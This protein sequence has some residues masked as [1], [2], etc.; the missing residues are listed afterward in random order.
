MRGNGE[1]VTLDDQHRKVAG[2]TVITQVLGGLVSI[3]IVIGFFLTLHSGEESDMQAMQNLLQTQI[4]SEGV[5]LTHLEDTQ[6]QLSNSVNRLSDAQDRQ[7]DALNQLTNALTKLEA[8]ES[9]RI[10]R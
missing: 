4:N 5:R 1:R 3:L 6:A 9:D 2:I 7:S 8:T 10:K